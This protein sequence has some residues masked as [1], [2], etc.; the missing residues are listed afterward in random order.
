LSHI[1]SLVYGI[2]STKQLGDFLHRIH[3]ITASHSVCQHR[4]LKNSCYG[5]RHKTV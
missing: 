2:Q 4:R 5:D 3:D 1:D